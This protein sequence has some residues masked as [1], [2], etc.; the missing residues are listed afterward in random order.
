MMIIY[1]ISACQKETSK[2]LELFH[3]RRVH[4]KVNFLKFLELVFSN[5]S[6]SALPDAI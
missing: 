2:A 5:F 6:L 1:L 4:K 3:V